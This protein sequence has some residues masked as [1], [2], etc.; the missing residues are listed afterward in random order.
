LAHFV[1]DI[2]KEVFD[3]ELVQFVGY[4]KQYPIEAVSPPARLRRTQEDRISEALPN[5]DTEFRL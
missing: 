4:I 2:E 5:V 1:T 3:D